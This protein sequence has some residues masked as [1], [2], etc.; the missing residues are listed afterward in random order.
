[1]ESKP[2]LVSLRGNSQSRKT[3]RTQP[4]TVTGFIENLATSWKN[5]AAELRA[6]G[7]DSQAAALEFCSNSLLEQWASWQDQP[8]DLGTAASITGRSYSTIQK[9]VASGAVLNSG[10]PGKPK[11]LRRNLDQLTRG[12]STS[13]SAPGPDLST[14]ILKNRLVAG[15]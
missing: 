14:E 12:E 9:K 2:D 4:T 3:L 13:P 11:I 10:R 15:R 6:L 8:L 1:M 5:K 7:A